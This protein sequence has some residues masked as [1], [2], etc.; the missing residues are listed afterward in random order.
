MAV[1]ISS[2]KSSKKEKK[3]ESDSEI[4]FSTSPGKAYEEKASFN[5]RAIK[6]GFL[7]SKSWTDKEGRYQSEESY[8][9]KNPLEIEITDSS[10]K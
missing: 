6:N 8:S 10:K 5:V 7:V 1:K 4:K 2:N 9:E 3:A